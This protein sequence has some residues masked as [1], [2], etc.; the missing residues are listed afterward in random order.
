MSDGK[1]IQVNSPTPVLEE[2]L[3]GDNQ[4]FEHIKFPIKS[5]AKTA[6]AWATSLLVDS[7]F[8]SIWFLAQ[9]IVGRLATSFPAHGTDSYAIASVQV[10]FAISTIIPI[11]LYIYQDTLIMYYRTKANIEKARQ[12]YNYIISTQNSLPEKV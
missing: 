12:I 9:S 1:N 7:V 11:I 3:Q 6:L 4:A 5:K 8:L 2:N 10:L